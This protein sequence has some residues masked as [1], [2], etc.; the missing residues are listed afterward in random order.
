VALRLR[1]STN[2]PFSVGRNSADQKSFAQTVADERP[3]RVIRERREEKL[4][5]E[6][7]FDDE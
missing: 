7:F 6:V 1:L 3:H 5:S 2:L 4:A